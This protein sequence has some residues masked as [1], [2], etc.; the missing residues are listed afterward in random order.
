MLVYQI[1]AKFQYRLTQNFDSNI[2]DLSKESF[3]ALSDDHLR[4]TSLNEKL[5]NELHVS[6]LLSLLSEQKLLF[7]KHKLHGHVKIF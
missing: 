6:E 1:L 7:I 2:V 4:N 5:N 3:N